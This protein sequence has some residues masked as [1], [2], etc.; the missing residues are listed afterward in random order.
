MVNAVNKLIIFLSL[1][2]FV[3]CNEAGNKSSLPTQTNTKADSKQSATNDD[4]NDCDQLSQ[5]F[6][7]YDQAI[8]LVRSSSFKISETVNTSRSSWIRGAEYY[9]CDG[10]TGYFIIETP[11][12]IYIHADMPIS[13]WQ[14]FK[15]ARSFGS[16]YDYNIKGRYRLYLGN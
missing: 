5:K 2:I 3:S 4:K 6:T 12:R 14:Q 10:S 7:S 9:S 11:N 8:N 16:F 13:V 15:N 1:A